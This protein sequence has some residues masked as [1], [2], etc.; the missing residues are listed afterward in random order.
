MTVRESE[1]RC[2]A[3]DAACAAFGAIIRKLLNRISV[4][5]TVKNSVFPAAAAAGVVLKNS[6]MGKRAVVV[7][8]RR[9]FP[10]Q[11]PAPQKPFPLRESGW[12]GMF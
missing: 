12:N 2:F 4:C 10:V 1:R 3:K 8:G 11:M 6:F 9:D 7:L 5:G